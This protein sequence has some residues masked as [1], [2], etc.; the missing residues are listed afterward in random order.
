MAGGVG[1]PDGGVGAVNEAERAGREELK[2]GVGV[3][4]GGY[5]GGI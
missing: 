2:G 1:I 3:N 4:Y 5:A